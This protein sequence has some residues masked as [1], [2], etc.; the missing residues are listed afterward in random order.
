LTRVDHIFGCDL[1]SDERP[2][3]NAPDSTVIWALRNRQL[4]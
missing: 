2:N 4:G 3:E 1:R